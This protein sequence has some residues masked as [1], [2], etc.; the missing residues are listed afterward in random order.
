MQY[1]NLSKPEQNKIAVKWVLPE[2]TS[3]V[4]VDEYNRPYI[5]NNGKIMC[6][7]RDFNNLHTHGRKRG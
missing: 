6:S 3:N 7:L 2:N 1:D 4:E 5:Q